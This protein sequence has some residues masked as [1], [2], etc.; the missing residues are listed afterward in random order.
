MIFL[1]LLSLFS[2]E[3]HE[4]SI[5]R[6]ELRPEDS[7]ITLYIK[8]DRKDLLEAI[9]SNCTDY[10][11][12]DQCFEDYITSHFTLSFDGKPVSPIHNKHVFNDEFIELFFDLNT[13]PEGVTRIE[14]FNNTFLDLYER[15]ENILYFLLNDKKRSFRMNKDRVR[16]I[17][18]Y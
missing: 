8:L 18:Q 13:S 15:Q 6:F 10:N 16:I 12:L 1:I 17:V 5:G 14:V 11:K 7:Q 4:F 2:K 3:S 9:K